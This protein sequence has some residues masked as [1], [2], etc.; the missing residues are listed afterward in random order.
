M[1]RVKQG[2]ENNTLLNTNKCF[3]RN[4][5]YEDPR[6]KKGVRYE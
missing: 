6:P 5:R 3:K 2:E 4:G 1:M